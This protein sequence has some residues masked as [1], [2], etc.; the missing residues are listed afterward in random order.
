LFHHGRNWEWPEK[1]GSLLT[2]PMAEFVFDP[3]LLTWAMPFFG[4]L[5]HEEYDYPDQH[6]DCSGDSREEE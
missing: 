4:W 5:S 2:V 1:F 6:R 3:L